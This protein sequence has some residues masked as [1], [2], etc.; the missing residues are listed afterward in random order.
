MTEDQHH[1]RLRERERQ[2]ERERERDSEGVRDSKL[3]SAN[4]MPVPAAVKKT[5]NAVIAMVTCATTF[6]VVW[7]SPA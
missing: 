6:R 2:R 3:E 1:E 5:V 7:L 4:I